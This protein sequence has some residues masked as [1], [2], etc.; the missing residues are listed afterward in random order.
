MT[1]QTALVIL[2]I[3]KLSIVFTMFCFF[4]IIVHRKILIPKYVDLLLGIAIMCG[5]GI[6]LSNT[7][8][9]NISGLLYQLCMAALVF[10]FTL[11]KYK[12]AI[13]R[14]NRNNRL[15]D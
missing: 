7:Y 8:S 9:I 5:C 6:L 3:S 11:N 10:V 13:R 12:N 2:E 15:K 1:M 4:F 14:R